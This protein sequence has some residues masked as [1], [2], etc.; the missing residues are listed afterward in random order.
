MLGQLFRHWTYQL[1]APGA[2]LR[3]RYDSFRKLLEEDKRCLELITALEEIRHGQV[4]ADWARVESLLR[5]LAWASASLAR[6]LTAMNPGQYLDLEPSLR[7][8][9]ARLEPLARLPEPDAAP[10]YVLGLEQA[11]TLHR[12]A[13]GKAWNLGRVLAGAGLPVPPGFV[14][15]ASAFF[16]FLEHN[17][18][19][20]RLG[21]LLARVRLDEPG[22][23]E[24]LCA[25][26]QAMVLGGEL[27]PLVEQAVAEAATGLASGPGAARALAVRSSAVGE[28]SGDGGCHGEG[29]EVSFAGQ[30]ESI[31]GV[32]PEEA[33]QA[34][35]R[36]IASK[37]SARAV[38][39]RVRYGLADSETPMAVLVLAMVRARAS[40]VVYSLDPA[41]AERPR[42]G[43]YAVRGL[44][45]SLVDGSTLPDMFYLSRPDNP[46]LVKSVI[47]S[48]VQEGVAGRPMAVLDRVSVK[49][50]ADW[51]LVLERLF[52]CPQDVEWAQD[53][54]GELYVIQ[55]RP[56][57]AGAP[58]GGAE[59]QSSP[60]GMGEAD[61][62]AGHEVLLRAGMT[63]SGGVGIGRA[64]LLG[65]GE[66]LRSVPGGSVLVCETLGPDLVSLLGRVTAIVAERGSRA[67][68][69]A[70]VAREFG[71]PVIV[72]ATDA[73]RILHSGQAVTVDAGRP[74][75]YAGVVE[76]LRAAGREGARRRTTPLSRRMERIMPLVSPLTLT[77][78]QS[79]RFAARFCESV[80]DFVRFCHEKGAAEMFSLVDRG[81]R[82]LSKARRLRTGLSMDFYVLDVGGREPW[83]R[84]GAS[85]KDDIAPEALASRPM[86]ALWQGLTHRD[87]AWAKSLRHMD[88]QAFDRV[89]AGV[90]V[91]GSKDLAS[92]A[93][94]AE[95]YLHAMV[96]FGYHFAVVD[97]L[98]S[99]HDDANYVAFRFKGGGADFERRLLRLQ[100]V[101]EVLRRAGFASDSRGDLLDAR[102]ARQD[103]RKCLQRLSLLGILLGQTR[104]LDMAMTDAAQVERMVEEFWSRY[105]AD[106]ESS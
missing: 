15:S 19:A 73:S 30:Y 11:A 72:G 85:G 41:P 13:G 91:L 63:A 38:A 96:R 3:G 105:V 51:G 94:L 50:L 67:S 10:P 16:A 40:G 22:R 62:A 24:E 54:D 93:V 80:H 106:I 88:W 55:S 60:E 87:V 84:S 28:D 81:G 52:G 35:R 92:Y 34:W 29:S 71:L 77:D 65:P 101:A 32:A 6:H 8:L 99:E 25:E 98:C 48:S 78:P 47:Q 49:T 64:H 76:G 44:G 79:P 33:G 69:F 53:E 58:H 2:L 97:A 102:F 21:E 104:L 12:K 26:M 17:G 57:Q 46:A 18:L 4:Q 5:A 68:H 59:S 37:Y 23:L 36:V 39:Y 61:P 90:G 1:L 20:P 95:D 75:I 31:L 7:D 42:I 14:V 82:G 66:P 56:L 83:S 74:A 70:S 86:R 100:F 45:E 27:P 89:S 103:E 43:V 9:L